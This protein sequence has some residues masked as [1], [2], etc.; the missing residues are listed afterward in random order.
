MSDEFRRT[1]TV[2]RLGGDE[3]GALLPETGEEEAAIVVDR[4]MRRTAYDAA[5]VG[6]VTFSAGVVTCLAPPESV[7][8][9][10]GFADHLM[11]A[12]KR[13]GKNRIMTEVFRDHA[14]AAGVGHA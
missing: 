11:Y 8:D 1:Y 7:D 13:T 12:A 9:V 3:F 10:I 5:P 6:D 2:A 14:A 4:L